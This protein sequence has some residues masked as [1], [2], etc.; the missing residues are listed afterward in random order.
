MYKKKNTV[1]MGLSTVP[2]F[3]DLG[4]YPPCTKW[5]ALDLSSIFPSSAY[6]KQEA[7][8]T[9]DFRTKVTELSKQSEQLYVGGGVG[10]GRVWR[11][12]LLMIR[13]DRHRAK[14]QKP[15]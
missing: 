13:L 6:T 8:L 1:Y 3:R 2:S 12:F 9:Y 11:V 5:E 15:C 14:K 4:I 10:V 7:S